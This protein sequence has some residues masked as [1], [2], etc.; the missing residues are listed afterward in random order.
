MAK[1][2]VWDSTTALWWEPQSVKGWAEPREKPTE[3]Q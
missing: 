3:R 2:S 1:A